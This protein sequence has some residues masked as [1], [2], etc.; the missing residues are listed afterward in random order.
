L[1]KLSHV[2]HPLAA[3]LRRATGFA[4]IVGLLISAVAFYRVAA[5]LPRSAPTTASGPNSPTVSASTSHRPSGTVPPKTAPTPTQPNGKLPNGPGT[6]EPGILLMASPLR[7]GSFDIAEI[8]LLTTPTSSIRLSPPELK[9][10]GSRFSKA[11]PVASQ[12]QVSAGSQP[13]LVPNGRIN[14]RIDLSLNAPAKR[15]ELRYHLSGIT[16]RSMPSRAGRALTA[17]SPLVAGASEDL[18]VAMI[19]SGNT[20]LNIECPVLRLRDRACSIGRPPNLRVKRKLPW[21]SA[22]IVVQFDLPRAQ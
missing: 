19:V 20:V 6:T 15:I 22:V 5:E 8:V 21:R 7:D 4:L 12:L 17:I 2:N 16:V 1:G 9:R 3:G 11:K 10:A 18:P 13:V 14:Q